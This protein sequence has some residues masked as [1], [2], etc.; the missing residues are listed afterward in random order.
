MK[1]R[2]ALAIL[3]TVALLVG[4]C[5]VSGLV[6]HAEDTA[7]AEPTQAKPAKIIY[8][9]N[10][11]VQ[12]ENDGRTVDKPVSIEVALNQLKDTVGGTI[13]LVENTTLEYGTIGKSTTGAITVTTAPEIEDKVKLTF[14][15][16]IIISN[17]MVLDNIVASFS[18]GFTISE[19]T[20]TT[21][22]NFETD[23][24][25]TNIYMSDKATEDSEEHGRSRLVLDSCK[26]ENTFQNICLYSASGK[27]HSLAGADIELGNI[28]INCIATGG[29]ANGEIITYT[30]DINIKVSAGTA[31][32]TNMQI[33]GDAT[34]SKYAQFAAGAKLHF[35]YPQ[36]MS[37]TVTRYFKFYPLLA[38]NSAEHIKN[39]HAAAYFIEYAAGVTDIAY[40]AANAVYTIEPATTPWQATASNG[41]VTNAVR[42][43]LPLSAAG[44]Y[45]VAEA[46]DPIESEGA[47]VYITHNATNTTQDGKTAATAYNDDTAG[48]HAACTDTTP[49]NNIITIKLVGEDVRL[50]N[51]SSDNTG[52]LK[53]QNA[54]TKLIVK[55]ESADTRVI[56]SGRCNVRGNVTLDNMTLTVGSNLGTDYFDTYSTKDVPVTL[57]FGKNFSCTGLSLTDDTG[58]SR[59]ETMVSSLDATPQLLFGMQGGGCSTQP[60]AI[61]IYG[62]SFREIIF[63]SKTGGNFELP[64]TTLTVDGEAVEIGA[65]QLGSRVA[66]TTTYTGDVTIVLKNGTVSGNSGKYI[67][68]ARLDGKST[69]KD[70]VVVRVLQSTAVKG[71]PQAA[72]PTAS[73]L[74]KVD[75]TTDIPFYKLIVPAEQMAAITAQADGANF[76]YTAPYRSLTATRCYTDKGVA[77]TGEV[78]PVEGNGSVLTLPQD[79]D[80]DGIYQVA[81]QWVWEEKNVEAYVDSTYGDDLF[82]DGTKL[83]PYCTLSTALGYAGARTGAHIYVVDTASLVSEIPYTQN[84]ITIAG[85]S[86]DAANKTLVR[87]G[88]AVDVRGDLT[89]DN[90]KLTVDG[91]NA[92][93]EQ[94]DACHGFILRGVAFTTTD[95]FES[96]Y[97]TD[98]PLLAVSENRG[99]ELRFDAMTNKPSTA[100]INNGNIKLVFFAS[101]YTTEGTTN[102]PGG[103]LILR[104]NAKVNQ[105]YLNSNRGTGTNSTAETI[106]KRDIQYVGNIN[107][108]ASGSSYCHSTSFQKMAGNDKNSREI[109]FADNCGIQVVDY[110]SGNIITSASTYPAYILDVQ[111]ASASAMR[112]Q[113][114][115]GCA[116]TPQATAGSFT[117]GGDMPVQVQDKTL[118][119]GKIKLAADTLTVGGGITKV[120]FINFADL[121]VAGNSLTNVFL[122]W[123]DEDKNYVTAETLT[124]VTVLTPSYATL[125]KTPSF[126]HHGVQIHEDDNNADGTTDAYSMRCIVK[127]SKAYWEELNEVDGISEVSR[128]TLLLPE[129]ALG[130]KELT[131]TEAY[132]FKDKTYYASAI[133][134]K[135]LMVQYP[136]LIKDKDNTYYNV[137]LT[138]IYPHNYKMTYAYRGYITYV[139]ASGVR[140]VLYAS[141]DNE[142]TPKSVYTTAK[143]EAEKTDAKED[144]KA[145]L[146]NVAQEANKAGDP[147]YVYR[148]DET[149][150][151]NAVSLYFNPAAMYT[152]RTSALTDAKAAEKTAAVL[153]AAAA[154]EP[155]AEGNKT[156]YIAMDGTDIN[157]GTSE[158]QPWSLDQLCD[159]LNDKTINDGDVILFRRGDLFRGVSLTIPIGVSVGAYGT[160]AKPILVGSDKNYAEMN[161]AGVSYWE[162]SGADNIWQLNLTG[163]VM[164]DMGDIG[165]DADIGNIVFDHG[166][167]VAS[168]GKKRTMEAMTSDYDFYYD[169]T[170][171]S[172]Y[173]YLSTGNPAD[174][175]CSIE[176]SP[177]RPILRYTAT[178]AENESDMV[179]DN[180]NLKYTGGHGISVSGVRAVTVRNCEVGYIGGA[181]TGKEEDDLRGRYGN[182]VEIFNGTSDCEVTNNWI[183]QCFDTGYTNQST[184]GTQK[185]ITASDNLIEYCLYNIEMW[186]SA[187]NEDGISTEY[188]MKDVTVRNNILRFAGYGFGT[189]GRKDFGNT[190]AVWASDI[191]MN[192]STTVCE[193][194]M[195]EDNILDYTYRYLVVASDNTAGG[196]MFER[197]V[198]SQ[199]TDEGRLMEEYSGSSD[200]AVAGVAMD[201]QSGARYYCP[202]EQTM[203]NSVMVYDGSATIYLDGNKLVA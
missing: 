42:G 189:F 61:N 103:T 69:Y 167:M 172:L 129:M 153:N 34:T 191:T 95:R 53:A 139:D 105:L 81:P 5:P 154:V 165:R 149:A 22:A 147:R 32:A 50:P 164:L 80:K 43:L 91:K 13:R 82:G 102:A 137:T 46:A 78:T 136:N 38:A 132:P 111:A 180:L 11:S 71:I 45:T 175:H 143:T 62:G 121:P 161:E 28:K 199:R 48:W 185:N 110:S 8:V 202:D 106:M 29:P 131:A 27:S 7:P 166:K 98:K 123:Q 146:A 97:I 107:I 79:Q 26:T 68:A 21:T 66:A 188:V 86:T 37:D 114:A 3:L 57:T 198:W 148:Y 140:R 54:N 100:T 14:T 116:L 120:S 23:N 178:T 67:C 9:G 63:G 19:A 96:G 108:I 56:L 193:N 122:G 160:G 150:T 163:N 119:A 35:Y 40:D 17:D 118:N 6:A 151:E 170:A 141:V 58:T 183:Y 203:K 197:N 92:D 84:G 59:D 83:R 145:L 101:D 162:A 33:F 196:L 52:H 47:V 109:T 182:G 70:G 12:P 24:T 126:E 144:A 169:A 49:T 16:A 31:F 90:M 55:A 99:P 135:K 2:K 201:G 190:S 18:G 158:E 85:T 76:D 4:L 184:V 44:R 127:M 87:L 179:I 115:A 93:S 25:T 186:V 174:Q 64:K 134:A 15:Q 128:G 195:I 157:E 60:V 88:A 89:L 73:Y 173:L 10:T 181:M 192:G 159:A 30:E 155:A 168:A 112:E 1:T 177:N 171:K 41:T 77:V 194:V 39:V 142:Y 156:Y 94:N 124:G 104:N 152:N 130:D 74:S 20:L 138:N 200:M 125:E 51:V 36:G 65:I 117:I 187:Y 75:E 113:L 133:E 72:A 176:V